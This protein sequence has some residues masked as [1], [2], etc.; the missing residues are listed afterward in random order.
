MKTGQMLLAILLLA[1]GM[2]VGCSADS[3]LLMKDLAKKLLR[4]E[5]SAE[6]LSTF[7]EENLEKLSCE[8]DSLK[9]DRS[10][11]PVLR[12]GVPIMKAAAFCG[13]IVGGIVLFRKTSSPQVHWLHRD[14]AGFLTGLGISLAAVPAA[15]IFL[16]WQCY[17]R[18]Y[19]LEKEINELLFIKKNSCSCDCS[20]CCDCDCNSCCDCAC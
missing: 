16:E 8:L 18:Y 3:E 20:C 15:Q 14:C 7:S 2:G 10:F 9:R 13:S 19:Y 6:I 4:G 12:V 17:P 11:W 5:V 1:W